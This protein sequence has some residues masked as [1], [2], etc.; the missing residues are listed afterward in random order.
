MQAGLL[1]SRPI[2]ARLRERGVRA[3]EK[4]LASRRRE[5][6]GTCDVPTGLSHA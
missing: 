5:Q 3:V 2:A 6:T 4:R 1:C